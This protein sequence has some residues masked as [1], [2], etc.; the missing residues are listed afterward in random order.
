MRKEDL[1]KVY[2]LNK[3]ITEWKDEIRRIRDSAG[4]RGMRYD[5]AKGFSGKCADVVGDAAA[6]IA[7]TEKKIR[8]KVTEL[9][10][11]RN[12][13]VRYILNID[14]CQTR[15]IFKLRCIDNMNW[16]QVADRIGGMNSEYSVKKRFY[17]Y[18]EKCS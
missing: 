1:M 9:E 16:N 15:L 11:A 8:K 2:Y 7:D 6:M 12:E 4:P 14:D 18:L 17:R 10:N 5:M 3:E 13:I